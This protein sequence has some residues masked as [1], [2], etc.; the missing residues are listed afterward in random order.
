[1]PIRNEVLKSF[2]GR[3]ILITGGTGMIGRQVV[4]LLEGAGARIKIVSLDRLVVSEKCEHVYGDLT[5]FNFCKSICKD[6]DFVFHVAG[7]GA[8]VKAIKSKIASHFVP[9]LMMSTNVLEA[10]RLEKVKKTVFVSSV[11]AYQ[12]AEVFIE[13]EY[14]LDT[15]PMDFA[16]WAKRMAEAQIYAYKTEYGLENMAI[17]RPPNVYGPGDNFHPENSLVIPSL[18]Y[19]IYKKENPLVVWGDGSSIRDFAYSRDIAEGIVLALYYGTRSGFVNLGSDNPCTVKTLVETLRSFLN[20][21]YVFDASKPKGV[22]KRI[23]D[24]SLA[25]KKIHYNP[26]TSLEDGLK[27]TWDWFIKHPDEHLKKVNYFQEK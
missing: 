11:G 16:G 14:R 18:L 2:E 13:S 24:L 1:M 6:M 5:D 17:V 23:M 15:I 21:D 26:T 4:D 3:N 20:F 10:S 27:K 9:L 12:D 22:A 7:I 19:R 8:S 25:R